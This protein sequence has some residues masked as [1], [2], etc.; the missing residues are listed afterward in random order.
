MPKNKEVIKRLKQL[1]FIIELYQVLGEYN[2]IAKLVTPNGDATQTYLGQ[3]EKVDGI[4]DIKSAMVL[5]H[6]KKS[7]ALPTHSLQKT[8]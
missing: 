7:S 8:L 1:D 2:L 4:L 6:H 3:L 5:E